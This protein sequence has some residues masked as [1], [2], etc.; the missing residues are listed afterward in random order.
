MRK[1]SVF[2]PQ[3]LAVTPV[4]KRDSMVIKNKSKN[5]QK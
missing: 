4:F 5:N 1:L 3:F 2:I